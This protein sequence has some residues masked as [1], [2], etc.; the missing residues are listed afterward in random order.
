M[1]IAEVADM[2]SFAEIFDPIARG[3]G[4]QLTPAELEDYDATLGALR[5]L[6]D[7]LD[8]PI[9]AHKARSNH[10]EQLNAIAD[11]RLADI[12]TSHQERL[13]RYAISFATWDPDR[14]AN[15]LRQ[16]RALGELSIR[17]R[18]VQHLRGLFDLATWEGV[19]T[20]WLL[21]IDKNDRDV[22]AYDRFLHDA[23]IC[24]IVSDTVWDLRADY[25]AGLT[26]IKPTAVNRAYLVSRMMPFALNVCRSLSP[27]QA[28]PLGQIT[29]AMVLG[30]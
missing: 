25:E 19:R 24:A 6:D 5:V 2:G 14:Q 1:S 26:Q 20:A 22:T 23:G 4:V 30:Q 29:R 8:E 10:E 28:R 15:H 9:D 17:K 11:G 16:H 3:F 18:E 27:E 12:T 21:Y 13:G 7:I